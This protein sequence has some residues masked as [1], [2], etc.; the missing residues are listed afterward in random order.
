MLINA[1]KTASPL[2]ID[3]VIVGAVVYP[4][5]G[6]VIVIDVIEPPTT[7]TVAVAFTL[8]LPDG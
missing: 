4:V 2:V 6:F 3:N 5:P 8:E 7:L 1:F